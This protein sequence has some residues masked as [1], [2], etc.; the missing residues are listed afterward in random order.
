MATYAKLE[1]DQPSVENIKDL[2]IISIVKDS[3]QL[4]S[5]DKEHD[6]HSE[7]NKYYEI[8]GEVVKENKHDCVH[9]ITNNFENSDKLSEIFDG[10]KVEISNQI[11]SEIKNIP[12][13]LKR[14]SED[15]HESSCSDDL[16]NINSEDIDIEIK[17]TAKLLQVSIKIH[18]EFHKKKRKLILAEIHIGFAVLI[19]EKLFNI[20][21]EEFFVLLENKILTTIEEKIS[22]IKN[23]KKIS[24]RDKEFEKK[25]ATV[26]DEIKKEIFNQ[27]K[28]FKPQDPNNNEGTFDG[29]EVSNKQVNNSTEIS[30]EIKYKILNK[31]YK[32]ISDAQETPN[33]IFDV[34]K[35]SNEEQSFTEITDQIQRI[36]QKEYFLK[37][38]YD[39]I[40]S[41]LEIYDGK[42]TLIE[43]QK[44]ESFDREKQEKEAIDQIQKWTTNYLKISDEIHK[45]IEKEYFCEILEKIYKEEDNKQEDNKLLSQEPNEMF[46]NNEPFGK[47]QRK[48]TLG[49][50]PRRR[51]TL[52]KELSNAIQNDHTKISYKIDRIKKIF[53]GT[54]KKTLH[55][56]ED[57]LMDM[58]H[59]LFIIFVIFDSEALIFMKDITQDYI[60]KIKYINVK[61]AKNT[62]EI[63]EIEKK[64]PVYTESGLHKRT[65]CAR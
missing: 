64:L 13:I 63:K 49:K 51:N 15:Q 2:V 24:I 26:A 53:S 9:I 14:I 21:L 50:K 16:N 52:N 8:I 57:V 40:H 6:K 60:N 18:H 4:S 46:E 42:M 48:N 30:K 20:L 34:Q 45:R 3:D 19:L 62:N 36:I 28:H 59:M 35:T 10:K 12:K 39:K 38:I 27:F 17:H 37:R 61:K 54:L 41:E 44:Q 65:R 43:E 47:V 56:K 33:D 58:K 31:F 1:D 7:Q 25:L 29:Q 23:S 5:N 32:R 11:K 55:L 22:I